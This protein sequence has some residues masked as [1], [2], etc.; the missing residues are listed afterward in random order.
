MPKIRGGKDGIKLCEE[1]GRIIEVVKN[2]Y[3]LTS[4]HNRYKINK[5]DNMKNKDN[6]S[7][8]PNG[9][10][11]WVR[12]VEAT[13]ASLIIIG[14]ILVMMSRQQT[15]T[16]NISDEI[17]EKQRSILDVISKN[18]SLRDAIL[19]NDKTAVNSA[20]EKRIPSSWGFTTNICELNMVCSGDVP[21]DREVYATE[22]VISST[23]T[24]YD[25][26]KLRFFVWMK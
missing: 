25:P 8:L 11:A 22:I 24:K 13:I 12:I 7:I 19:M 21:Y 1:R 4:L 23:L 26:K 14:F 5:F 10:K 18:E 15:T 2:C 9:K 16:P 17:Y 6:K 20:I 3:I